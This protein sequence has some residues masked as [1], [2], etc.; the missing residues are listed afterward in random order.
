MPDDKAKLNKP[1]L[2]TKTANNASY[3]NYCS[4]LVRC[5]LWELALWMGAMKWLSA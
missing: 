4:L 3:N 1:P 5:E 2:T